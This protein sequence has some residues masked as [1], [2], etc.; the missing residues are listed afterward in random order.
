DGARQS[1]ATW[2][3]TTGN[4][5][6]DTSVIGILTL[7][8]KKPVTR[9]E[10]IVTIMKAY[11]IEPLEDWSDNFA[12]ASGE[13]AE[14]Y[15]KAKEIGFISGIG[16]NRIGADILLTREMLFTMLYNIES[17]TGKIQ[18][19]DISGIDLAGFYDYKELSDWSVKAVKALVKSGRL[20]I[21]GSDLL[22]ES[23][24]DIE[25]INAILN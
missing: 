6:Q 21:D 10:A 3:D 18:E 22:P 24:V 1:I 8:A 25:E 20:Q 19:A 13:Y 15:A 17:V 5:Y 7:K 2:N 9:G 4:A 11:G 12:D 23:Y 14:Y 16:G